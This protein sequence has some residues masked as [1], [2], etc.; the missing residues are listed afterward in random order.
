MNIERIGAR[1]FVLVGGLLWAAAAFGASFSYLGESMTQAAEQAFIFLVLTVIAFVVGWF[2]EKL[3]ALLLLLG[4]LGIVAWG[5]VGAWE[6]GVW[7]TM[8]AVLI[9]PMLIAALLFLL[10]SRM[11]DICTLEGQTQE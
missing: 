4:A 7:L 6:A 5:I 10:A 8:G 1:A 2:Y 11:Q 3:A 9:A